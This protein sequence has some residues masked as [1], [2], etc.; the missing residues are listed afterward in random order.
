MQPDAQAHVGDLPRRLGFWS[1]TAIV[2]GIIIGSGIFRTP[3]SIAQAVDSVWV[4]GALWVAG[5]LITLCLGLCVAEL[6]TLFPN[7]GG[8]YVYLREAFGPGVAFVF[9]WTFLI[10]NPSVW[11]AIALIFGQY[12]GQFIPLGPHGQRIAAIALVLFVTLTNYFSVQLAASI[13]NAA[14]SAKAFALV[15]I[16]VA[17][18]T[19]G[20]GS[21]GALAQPATAHW[22]TT[23]ALLGAFLAVLFSYEGVAGSSSVFGEVRDPARTIPPALIVSVLTVMLLY[24]LVNAA[25]LYVLPLD[26]VANSD[27]VAA[28]AMETVTGPSAAKIIAACVMLSTFGA[29]CATAIADPRVFY[30]M[31]RDGLFFRSIGTVHPRFQTPHIAIVISGALA[32]VYIWMRSFEEL[33]AQFVLG[34]WPFYA[35]IVLGQM[36]LRKR[37]PDAPRPF[38]TPLYP[39]VPLV[40]LGAAILLLVVSVFELPMTSLLNVSIVV[41]G[42]P[43]YLLW[44]RSGAKS[45]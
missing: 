2:I 29:V 39:L 32:C 27:L 12:L 1:A 7:A 4:I 25:Y 41:M 9:G 20:D 18:F 8:M 31:A 38:R 35:L 16:A 10:I 13:Q 28:Q 11:A 44:R 23:G 14:T 3:A 42:V 5:G 30:A 40:F 34:F 43:V 15:A 19:L 26:T 6:G 17:V 22:P 24:L 21:A 37:R 36:L 45:R 33:A